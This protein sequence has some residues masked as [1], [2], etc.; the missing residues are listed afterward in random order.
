[1]ET[2]VLTDWKLV[3]FIWTVL[4]ESKQRDRL[5]AGRHFPKRHKARKKKPAMQKKKTRRTSRR[6]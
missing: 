5:S 1:M 6:M 4:A 3:F 2:P